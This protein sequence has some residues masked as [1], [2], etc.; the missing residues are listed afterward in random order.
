MSRFPRFAILLLL[1]LAARAQEARPAFLHLG[2]DKVAPGAAA[3]SLVVEGGVPILRWG[4][5]SLGVFAGATQ[6]RRGAFSAA[7][8]RAGD[9]LD[10]TTSWAG[11]YG[12]SAYWSFGLAGEYARQQVYVIPTPATQFY[13]GINQ[14][15]AGAGCFVDLHGP[16]GFGAFI[17]AGT[18]SGFGL[19]LSWHF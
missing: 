4:L 19:G 5:A 10:K 9:L 12:G 18:Q 16:S 2:G 14:L 7:G 1:P 3:F 13:N 17:R 15:R 8:M 11:V 6:W